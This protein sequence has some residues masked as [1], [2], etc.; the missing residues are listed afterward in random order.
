MVIHLHIKKEDVSKTKNPVL[1]SMPCKIHG[2]D[3]ANVEKYFNPYMKN[4]DDECK[5]SS[6]NSCFFI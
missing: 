3:N 5:F 2:D 6:I 1:H 4:V